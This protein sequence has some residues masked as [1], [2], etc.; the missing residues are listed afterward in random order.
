MGH[1]S[2]RFVIA[3]SRCERRSFLLRSLRWRGVYSGGMG[4]GGSSKQGAGKRRGREAAASSSRAGSFPF[5][6]SSSTEALQPEALQPIIPPEA[7]AR[8]WPFAA[9][10]ATACVSL[11]LVQ[12]VGDQ[13]TYLQLFPFKLRNPD[14]ML[15]YRSWWVMWT[16]IGFLVLPAA[17]MLLWPGKRI[18]DCNLSWRGFREHFWIYVALYAAVFPVIYLVSWSPSFYSYYPMYPNAG[19]SWT[20]LLLWESLYAG[21]FIALEFFFRGF[22]VGGLGRYIGILGAPV[23]VMPYMMLHFAKPWPEAYAAIIAGF[24]LGWLAWKTKSIWGGVLIHCAVAVSMD[25]L[26]LSHRGQL[27]WLHG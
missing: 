27:P 7:A 16:V 24:V 6:A 25:L 14:W 26:A 18:R 17:F 8:F 23:S 2:R 12:F 1:P 5:D 13:S 10:C 21:Q 11:G 22:L 9:M 3:A 4:R 20:D 15:G 19:R